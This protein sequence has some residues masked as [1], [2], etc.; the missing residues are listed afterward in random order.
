MDHLGNK[1]VP[2][3]QAEQVLCTIMCVCARACTSC[4]SVKWVFLLR[5]ASCVSLT[6]NGSG[7]TAQ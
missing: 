5:S 3:E 2:R 4:L 1:G 7:G 6:T